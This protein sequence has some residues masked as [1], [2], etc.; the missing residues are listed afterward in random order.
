MVNYEEKIAER[1]TRIAYME[2]ELMQK[3]FRK[4]KS[5]VTL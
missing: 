2:K 5:M 4:K 3:H 1:I